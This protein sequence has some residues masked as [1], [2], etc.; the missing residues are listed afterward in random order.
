MYRRS[1]RCNWLLS[2]SCHLRKELCETRRKRRQYNSNCIKCFEERSPIRRRHSQEELRACQPRRAMSM[3]QR[4]RRSLVRWCIQFLLVIR[5]SA[6][7]QRPDHGSG[8]ND[9]DSSAFFSLRTTFV[10]SWLVREFEYDIPPGHSTTKHKTIGPCE[11]Y[12][13]TEQSQSKISAVLPWG[14]LGH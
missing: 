14:I 12:L 10:S 3:C 7:N 6:M 4:K 5:G 2:Y 8:D 13:L 1:V 11:S 9:A